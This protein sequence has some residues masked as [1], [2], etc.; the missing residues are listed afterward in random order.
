[1]LKIIDN[2]SADTAKQLVG[3]LPDTLC[4]AFTLFSLL[5]VHR[6]DGA[7]VQT[8]NDSVTALVVS[9]GQTK[10]YVTAA[11]HA[12]F[13]ELQ[14][15]LRTLGGEVLHCVPEQ[16]EKL[17]ITPFSKKSLMELCTLP[18]GGKQAKTV[19]DNLRPIYDLLVQ[20]ASAAAGDTADFHKYSDRAYK[21]W[22]SKTVRGIFGG[23]TVVKAVYVGE[24]SLLAAGVADILG[25][26]V[27]IRDV[28]TDKDY[29]QMGYGSDCVRGLCADLK[30]A[31]NRI[32]L[33]CGDLKTERFYQKSGFV[34]K[35]YI[36]QGIVE[37]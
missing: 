24:N 35:G 18:D 8:E 16:A 31:D 36:Q 10:A 20:A 37:L 22:L 7:W 26:Y 6:V 1:M 9:E 32:F 33:L 3:V 28:V 34:R 29:R 2:L 15:F 17:G 19:T 5:D 30:T 13:E 4:T 21:E 23:Y 11:E 27:Y 25:K 14:Y 12:D